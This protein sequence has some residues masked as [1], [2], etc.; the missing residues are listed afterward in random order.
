[1][2]HGGHPVG[3]VLAGG[4]FA[5]FF[6]ALI[7]AASLYGFIE[8]NSGHFFMIIAFIAGA[9]IITTEIIPGKPTRHKAGWV[10]ALLA[11][12]LILDLG[13]AKYAARRERKATPPLDQSQP[14]SSSLLT[15]TAQ[16]ERTPAP[17]ANQ[18]TAPNPARTQQAIIKETPTKP[19]ATPASVPA[20]ST[21]IGR[22]DCSILDEDTGER[23]RGVTV[24]ALNEQTK[25]EYSGVTNRLGELTLIVPYGSYRMTATAPTYAT[26]VEATKVSAESGLFMPR[27][28]KIP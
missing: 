12:L 3:R 22:I 1:M 24:I 20:L 11:V 6:G 19:P 21:E 17:Q 13:G 25:Q 14:T 8:V 5:L 7:Q 18:Q 28:Q 9:L 23:L 15:P 16:P 26:R 10:L 27:L 4:L 2:S